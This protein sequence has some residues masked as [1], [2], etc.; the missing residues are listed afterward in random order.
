MQQD[1]IKKLIELNKKFYETTA[2]DFDDSRHY[3]WTGWEKILTSIEEKITNTTNNKVYEEKYL[4]ILD[5]GCGNARFG[6]FLLEKMSDKLVKS[7]KK[8]FYHG[9]DSNQ[10]LLDFGQKKLQD[11]ISNNFDFKLEN[12][13]LFDLIDNQKFDIVVVFGVVHHIPSL[14]KRI[15]FFEMCKNYKKSDGLLIVTFWQ[16]QNIARYSKDFLQKLIQENPSL[17]AEFENN[18]FLLDW[19]RGEQALRFCHLVDESEKNRILKETDLTEIKSFYADSKT[20]NGNL[21]IICK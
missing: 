19:R 20:N 1:T 10:T 7:N 13:D 18:D 17:T 21:Y 11:K 14:Q 15:D 12:R 4:R 8:L 16:F 6:E 2:I 9:I 5:I 3:F